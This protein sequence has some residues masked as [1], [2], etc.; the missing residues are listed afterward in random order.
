MP[1]RRNKPT[2]YDAKI[3]GP[4]GKKQG[5]LKF[6]A[7]ALPKPVQVADNASSF[8]SII[9]GVTGIMFGFAVI[10][11]KRVFRVSTAALVVAGA[12]GFGGFASHVQAEDSIKDLIKQLGEVE[13]SQAAVDKL[14]ALAKGDQRKT[15][16]KELVA[17]AK[18]DES[19]P[20]R[21]WAIAALSDVSGLAVDEQLT[22]IHSDAK[23]PM[24]V[25]TWAAAARVAMTQSTPALIA[26]ANLVQTFPA[27]GRPIGMRLVE[28]L[29]D[30]GAAASP[31]DILKISLQIPQLQQALGAPILALGPKKLSVVMATAKDQNV[32]RQAAAYLGTLANQGEKSVPQAVFD[33]YKFDPKAKNVAWNGG[34]LFVPGI[35]WQKKEAQQL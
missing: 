14:V 21:G 27:L 2:F 26:K 23:Q 18:T 35:N 16:V 34:P 19:F 4:A 15:V 25:R 28:S 12:V 8:H 7:L 1:S 30:D 3:N 29:N 13:T 20:R 6:G 32:R 10:S 17:V 33:A 9:W 31:E 5:I 24:L 11:L 22:Q